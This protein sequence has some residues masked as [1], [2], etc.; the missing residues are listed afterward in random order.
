LSLGLAIATALKGGD[1]LL[2]DGGSPLIKLDIGAI[3]FV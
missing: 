1:H 2:A 3:A